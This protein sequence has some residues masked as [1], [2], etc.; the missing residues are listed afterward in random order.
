MKLPN[1]D[2]SILAITSSILKNYGI[3]SPYPSM[4]DVD[5][6][7]SKKYKN[8]FLWIIDG[9]GHYNLESLYEPSDGIR[10][11]EVRPIS[12]IYPSTTAAA[13]TVACSGLPPVSTGWIGWH[14]YFNEFQEDYVLF[15][16]NAFYKKGEKCPRNIEFDVLKYDSLWD[17][18]SR[19]GYYGDFIYPE[20][21]TPRVKS[22]HDQCELV[23]ETAKDPNKNG[24]VYVYWDKL[25]SLMHEYGITSVEVRSHAKDINMELEELQKKLPEDTLLIVTADHGHVDINYIDL[26]EYP[27]LVAT[28]EK[29]P[30][31]ESRAMSF[32]IKE[33]QKEKFKK[34]FEENFSDSFVLYSHDQVFDM[35]LLGEGE[36]YP[37]I[38]EFMGDFFACAISD[39]AFKFKTSGPA[40]GNHAG[41]TEWEMTT[42]LILINNRKERKNSKQLLEQARSKSKLSDGK[43]FNKIVGKPKDKSAFRRVNF[44]G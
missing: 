12:S 3:D 15:L 42:P 29:Y 30:T 38:H 23:L 10:K 24:F 35:H 9:L 28:F 17:K 8:V 34:I 43:N 19:K 21:R 37:R 13:T 40:K 5:Q 33:E 32:Y 16:D 44:N 6:E 26:E 39:K 4:K 25:D 2:D 36:E 27:E 18:V 41:L 31:I 7:L 22:F 1:Y 20:F 14:Q 11:W